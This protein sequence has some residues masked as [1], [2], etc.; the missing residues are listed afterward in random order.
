MDVKYDPILDKLRERDT[1]G[2]GG[3]GGGGDYIAGAG[4]NSVALE[5]G[6]IAVANIPQSY[7]TGLTSALNSKQPVISSGAT[8]DI[9][10]TGN[11]A[12]LDSATKQQVIDS[13]VASASGGGIAGNVATVED[14]M[15]GITGGTQTIVD[16]DSLRG[17]LTAGQAVDVTSKPDDFDEHV[18]AGTYKA[19]F[20]W[21][22]EYTLGFASFPKFA[23][24]LKY[25]LVADVQATEDGATVTPGGTWL[26]GG[27][28]AI[29]LP[30][31]VYTRIAMLFDSADSCTLTFGGTDPLVKNL[32]EYEVTA[33]S[34][35]AIAYIAA[36]SNP[37]SFQDYY[38]VKRDMVSPWTYIIDMGDSPMTTIAA[39]LA[40]QINATSGTHILTTDICPAGYVGREATVRL[41]VGEEGTVAVQSPLVLGSPIIPDAINNCVVRYRDGEAVLTVN[42]TIGGYIV[43][44]TSGT[45]QGTIYYGLTTSGST[46]YISISNELAGVGVDMGGAVTTGEKLVAGNGSTTILT[47]IV[48]CTSKTIFTNLAMSGAVIAGGTPSLVGVYIP[49]GGSISRSGTGEVQFDSVGGPGFID[50]GGS[51]YKM[52][53]GASAYVSGATFTNPWSKATLAGTENGGVFETYKNNTVKLD[54]CVMSGARVTRGG[55]VF[56]P[57]VAAANV[58]SVE[59]T[60]C[61]VTGCTCT[62]GAVCTASAGSISAT[63]CH[64]EKNVGPEFTLA[65]GVPLY[66]SNCTFVSG[67]NGMDAG[68]GGYGNV[69]IA[70]NCTI[71]KGNGT[72]GTIVISSGASIALTTFLSAGAG[73]NIE[74]RGGTCMVNG[75]IIESG[76]YNKI[77]S[78][79]G[80]AVAQ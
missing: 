68:F 52:P 1:G 77:A 44:A 24:G 5:G 62:G 23:S 80:S 59:L 7:V 50:M 31:G 19:T 29:P 27:S 22:R 39:G 40:Y 73:S 76:F 64:F 49:T 48:S 45:T 9:N 58:N 66:I 54:Y 43:V 47:G 28:A 3:G 21:P 10:I 6:T 78:S 67:Y 69:T 56:L 36:L 2:G 34:T 60:G 79:G 30:N 8:M 25:L 61:T 53:Q 20:L 42:D 12:L 4:I 32:R 72:S 14:L 33:C 55:L 37:D 26:S 15:T 70:G 18:A 71:G 41:F 74:V 46:P 35:E 75:A 13:A 63:N 57:Y 51:H 16:V 65:L 17:A 11:A 38:L